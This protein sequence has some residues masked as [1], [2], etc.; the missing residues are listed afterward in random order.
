MSDAIKVLVLGEDLAS[1][2]TTTNPLPVLLSEGSLTI[3]QVQLLGVNGTNL[4]VVDGLGNLTVIGQGPVAPGTAQAGSLLGGA[5]YTSGGITLTN[6]QQ[7]ALQLTSAGALITSGTFTGTVSSSANA[8]AAAPSYSEGTENPFSQN[9]SGDLRTIAKQSTSPW[10]VAGGGTAGS[11]ATGV[12]T[13]QGIA[14]MTPVQVSQATAGN[15]NATVVGTGTFAV[16]ATLAAETTKVIGTVNQGTSPWVISGSLTANQTVNVAQINGVTPL[17]GNG[18]TGT[19]S[20]RVTIAS[21]NTA[22]SV[23][24]TLSAET[25]K[26]IGVVRTADG[27]GNLLTS[28]G[29]ALDVNIKT[30]AASNISTNIAQ[31]NGVTVTMGNG[32]SGTGVQRVTLASD[33]TGQVTL[34]AGTQIAGKVGIDQTTAVTTNGVVIAPVSASAAGIAAVVSTALETGHIIKASAGNLYGLTVTSTSAA[35]MVLIFNS[36]TVPAAGAVTPIDFFQLPAASTLIVGYDPPLYCS[37]GIS[38]A[39]STA[40]TPFTKTDSATAAIS[41]KAA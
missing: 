40:T 36:T 10:I 31:M 32:A 37:T 30:S 12:A 14:S 41:G 27:S 39:F 1:P 22:F 19:G 13:I 5:V 6:G 35:G 4:A 3:G 29:N 38:V 20:Q 28:T 16:Q 8:T 18:V 17:M 11:A 21:D 15:L 26:V 2:A 24:A 34:A 33:S 25:T 7:A 23:N 9:L